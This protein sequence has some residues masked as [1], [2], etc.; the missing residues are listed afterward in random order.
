MTLVHR[1]WA[2]NPFEIRK[3]NTSEDVKTHS[4]RKRM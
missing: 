1:K 3:S 2:G 4:G